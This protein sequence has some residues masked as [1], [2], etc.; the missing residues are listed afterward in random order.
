[1]LTNI[2]IAVVTF[3]VS[4]QLAKAVI[5]KQTNRRM[6]R[7]LVELGINR[8]Q[9]DAAVTRLNQQNKIDQITSKSTNLAELSAAVPVVNVVVENQ[10]FIA[11]CNDKFITQQPLID[12]LVTEV[13]AQLGQLVAFTSEDIQVQE[14]LVNGQTVVSHGTI[15]N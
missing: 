3:I 11:Y 4:W 12:N 15:D 7:L 10:Q 14:E 8:D 5:K 2:I 13:H 1:M 9:L 6:S